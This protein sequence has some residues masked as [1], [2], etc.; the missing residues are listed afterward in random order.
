MNAMAALLA[1]QLA[2]QAS[3]PLNRA[4]EAAELFWDQF[5]AVQSVERITQTKLKEDGKVASSLTSEFDY[6]ALLKARANGVAVEESRVPRGAKAQQAEPLLLTSGFPAL[7]LLFHSDFR[8]KFEFEMSPDTDPP[9][10]TVRVAF[11]SKPGVHSMS[12]LK[13]NSRLYPILWRGFAWVEETTGAVRR[14]VTTLD[15]SMDD[16]GLAELRAEVEY[17][18]VSLRDTTYNLPA[19]VT[20]TAGTAKRRWRTVHEFSGYKMFTVTTSTRGE[21]EKP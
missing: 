5:I 9:A 12:A 8:D 15:G 13:L 14:I 7:L 18:P 16:I 4:A 20:V 6:V 10:G 3:T 11:K 19:R 17:K 1:L 21:V 2:T